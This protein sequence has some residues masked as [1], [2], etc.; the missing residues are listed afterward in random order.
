MKTPTFW[1]SNTPVS[2]ALLPLSWLYGAGAKAHQKSAHPVKLSVP[3]ICIGN[4]TAGG[5]GKTPVALY[6]GNM[7]KGKNI[8]AF[9]L[10]RGYGGKLSGPVLVDPQN[11][12][13]RD[14][15]DE[16]MLLAGLLPTVVAKDRKKG[17][18]FAIAQGAAA[19]VMDDGFQNFS[20]KKT[21][22]LLVIDGK[23]GLG[24]GLMLPAGPLREAPETAFARADAAIIIDGN[25]ALPPDLPV[26]SAHATLDGVA[27]CGKKLLAFC[28]IARPQKFFDALGGAG[29]SVTDTAAFP[30]HYPYKESDLNALIKKA[31]HLKATLAT[32]A[33]DAVRLPAS[34][35]EKILVIPM[36]LVFDRPEQLAHLIDSALAHEKN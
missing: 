2:S 17:A 6:V 14:V 33:K 21:L 12:T 13:A 15:G 27:V 31:A 20:L 26:I 19:I 24:N 34:F 23:Y 4:L 10:S 7:L 9:F 3:V 25:M 30:D 32:T 8:R 22:S 1:Q 11:H 28:G 36:E 29:A 35:K 16:S 5:A 18:E